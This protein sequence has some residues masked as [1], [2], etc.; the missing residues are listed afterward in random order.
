MKCQQFTCQN[1]PNGD[2]LRTGIP[3][4]FRTY[5]VPFSFKW[6]RSRVAAELITMILCY[7]LISSLHHRAKR[8]KEATHIR[9]RAGWARPWNWPIRRGRVTR[10]V[11]LHILEPINLVQ[12]LWW[13]ETRL[14]G[15]WNNWLSDCRLHFLRAKL[16]AGCPHQTF[17]ALVS[18]D[19]VV[20]SSFITWHSSRRSGSCGGCVAD[21][22][23]LIFVHHRFGQRAEQLH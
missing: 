2:S 9:S 7:S 19:W 18:S 13:R 10:K 16:S 15:K 20:N 8:G 11:G 22:V 23:W 17:T 14:A 4:C 3:P 5:F 21:G 1:I 6:L 12:Y